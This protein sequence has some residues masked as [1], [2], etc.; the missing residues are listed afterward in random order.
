MANILKALI[1]ISVIAGIMILIVMGLRA[2]FAKKMSPGVVTLLWAIVLLRLVIPFTLQSPVKLAQFIP[3]KPA[4]EAQ[5]AAETDEV[6]P[7][8]QQDT[9]AFLQPEMYS[10]P[11]QALLALPETMPEQ[12]KPTFWQQFVMFIKGISWWNAF[13]G[14][15]VM[16]AL[17]VVI[18]TLWRAILYKHKLNNCRRVTDGKIVELVKEYRQNLGIKRKVS[19]TLCNEGAI[20]AVFGYF[21]PHIVLPT[22]FVSSMD[23]STL[24]CIILHELCHVKR[25]DILK[26]YIWLIAKAIHWFNPL[27]WIAYK[28]LKDDMELCCDQ[29]VVKVLGN[30]TLRV[31]AV[32]DRCIQARKEKKLICR[33]I[34]FV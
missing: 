2:L 23:K 31:Y 29:M 28:M 9:Q 25:H 1:E 21:H 12:T 8:S 33:N 5:N 20:P 11:A 24:S 27:V 34:I 16:G 3:Q 15:W 13:A 18:L 17:L 32:A 6:V 30:K 7:Y 19:V 26:S 22:S 14:V 10:E 4:V